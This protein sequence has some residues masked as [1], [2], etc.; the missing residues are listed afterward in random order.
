MAVGGGL[1]IPDPTSLYSFSHLRNA[2]RLESERLVALRDAV[3]AGSRLKRGIVGTLG[4]QLKRLL[5]VDKAGPTVARRDGL[6]SSTLS[7][8]AGSEKQGGRVRT[9]SRERI[10]LGL[11]L[12][13]IY[14]TYF[15]W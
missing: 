13:N 3:D 10:G 2:A 7:G 5:P 9:Y 1:S 4:E 14:A 15:G 6:T 12:S 11:P 8:E